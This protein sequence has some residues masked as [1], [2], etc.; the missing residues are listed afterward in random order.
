MAGGVKKQKNKKQDILESTREK[1]VHSENKGSCKENI[2]AMNNSKEEEN[3][4]LSI[5]FNSSN[6]MEAVIYSEI[7]GKPRS[8]RRGRWR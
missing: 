8:R 2:V 7:L 4:P 3:N 1:P 5:R 6:L